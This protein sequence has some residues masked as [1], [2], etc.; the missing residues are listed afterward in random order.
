MSERPAVPVDGEAVSNMPHVRRYRLGDEDALVEM[1][2]SMFPEHPK[3][4]ATWRWCYRQAP[5]GPADILVLESEDRVVGGIVHV[6]VA[7]WLEGRRRRLAIGCDLM[8]QPEFRGQGWS[9]QLVGAFVASEHGF[10][11]NFGVVNESSSYVMGRY[12]GT[13]TM[14][15]VDRW[16]RFRSRGVRQASSIRSVATGAERLH[17]ATLSWPRPSVRVEDLAIPCSDLDDLARESAD[18]AACIRIRDSAY[19]RWHWLEQPGEGWRV[20]AVREA[21]GGL[22]GFAVSGTRTQSGSGYRHGVIADLLARDAETTRALLL[23]SWSALVR[24]GCHIVSCSY[25]D[26]R[27]WSRRAMFRAG[28]RPRPGPLVACGSLSPAAGGEVA[29]LESWYLTHGDTDI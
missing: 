10:D 4:I 1:S 5:E 22:S 20:R 3:S 26:P 21:D 8:I 29:R 6:P 15:R 7:V 23:D 28:F 24:D 27:P 18:F 16:V 9:Q 13:V 25:L 2:R 14:G 19:L 11:I 17:G 12:A